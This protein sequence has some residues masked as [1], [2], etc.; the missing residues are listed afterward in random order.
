M[1]PCKLLIY[2]LLWKIS[3]NSELLDYPH[4][5]WSYFDKDPSPFI[6]KI[7][8][9]TMNNTRNS[10]QFSYL[11]MK[12]ISSVI[13]IESL[14]DYFSILT[15]LKQ[16]D[17]LRILLLYLY[18]GWWFDASTLVASPA[19]LDTFVD[20]A[21]KS[22]AQMVG[23]CL[24]CPRLHIETGVM[25]SPPKSMT[26]KIWLEEMD[27][28]F[29]VG[30]RNYFY[31]AFRNGVD[32][33]T[34]LFRDYPTVDTYFAVFAAQAVAFRVI[35]RKTVLIIEPASRYIY[36]YFT[37]CH[38]NKTC[39]RENIDTINNYPITKFTGTTRRAFERISS[40][41]W[42]GKIDTKELIIEQSLNAFTMHNA[43]LNVLYTVVT[44]LVILI[45][46]NYY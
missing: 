9:T 13:S 28:M 42:R 24:Y 29:R 40:H 46:I 37:N 20:R 31:R 27:K 38:W 11:T 21:E 35:P 22:Q 26:F 5:I 30:I 16:S 36:S 34:R 12:N 41:G 3:L 39:I 7:L 43:R 44:G 4:I 17:Y 45:G 25:Y 18:G 14:P 2:L 10:W 1:F 19:L 33:S 32:F 6:T 8:T 15:P 23:F